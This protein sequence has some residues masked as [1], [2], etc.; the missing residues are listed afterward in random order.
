MSL[1]FAMSLKTAQRLHASFARLEVRAIAWTVRLVWPL[2][3][4]WSCIDLAILWI[5]AL[6]PV[7]AERKVEDAASHL[8][9]GIIIFLIWFFMV[10]TRGSWTMNKGGK[11]ER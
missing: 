3:L 2:A 9:G 11:L 10:R 6:P 5:R 1:R 8:A 4:L 7:E